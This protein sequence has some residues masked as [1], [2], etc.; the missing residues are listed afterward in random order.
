MSY[1]VRADGGRRSIHL[2]TPYMSTVMKTSSSSRVVGS[3]PTCHR[4]TYSGRQAAV[5]ARVQTA[6]RLTVA[7][8]NRGPAAASGFAGFD[9]SS[10]CRPGGRRCRAFS[11]LAEHR[12]EHAQVALGRVMTRDP[13]APGQA[14]LQHVLRP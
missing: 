3:G 7:A 5:I 8:V 10:Q 2:N 11:R 14:Q 4:T 6:N 13:L 1:G 12:A 9:V